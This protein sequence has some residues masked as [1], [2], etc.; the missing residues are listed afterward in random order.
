MFFSTSPIKLLR[1]IRAVTITVSVLG[2]LLSGYSIY[3]HQ[4]KEAN[5]D[6]KAFCDIS[7]E[8]S[9]SKVFTS[10]FVLLLILD[11]VIN[12]ILMKLASSY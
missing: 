8:V 11:F 6:Y 10:R 12:F 2:I 9:C 7:E 4:R 5:K 1:K 3:V